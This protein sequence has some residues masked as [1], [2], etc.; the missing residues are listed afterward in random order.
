MSRMLKAICL[1]DLFAR[2][3][4][5]PIHTQLGRKQTNAGLPGPRRPEGQE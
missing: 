5:A 4:L 3:R 1:L 2:T